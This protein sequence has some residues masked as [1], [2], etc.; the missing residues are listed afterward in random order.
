[1]PDFL[2]KVGSIVLLLGG[3]IFVHE[4]GHFLVAKALGVKVVRFSIG[5][6]ARLFGFRRGETE[7]RISL[8]PLG[9]YVKMAGDDP[10]E[11]LAPE[12]R[13]RGFLE[14]P[15]WK[16]LVIAFAGPA[17]NLIFP[18]II[19]FALMVGQNGEPTAGP[20]VGTVSPGS[21]AA[22]AGLRS[23]DRILSVQAPGQ[24]ATPVRYFN[25]L[26]D[27]VS[28][29]PGEPVTF[30]IEREG[31]TLDPV[32][33]VPATDVESNV[34][35]TTRRGVIGVT[36]FYAP[37]LVAP[38]RPGAA[39]PLEPFD[40]VVSVNGKKIRHL[41]ELEH[42]VRAASCQPVALEVVRE[43]AI[44]LPG[45]TLASFDPARL[46]QVP[47][48]AEGRPTFLPADP[49]LSTFVAA[50][51][52]GSPADKAGLRRGD[53]IAAINGKPVR[54][55]TRDVNALGR[56]F[57]VGKPVALELA[58]GRKTS[59]V[60]ATESYVDDLTK[61][62]AERLLLGFH[63]DRRTLVDPRSLVVA[64]VPLRLGAVEMAE[65]AW[66]ELSRAV[67]YTVLGI[68]RIITGQISFKTVGGPI[69]LFSIASEAAE[70]GWASFLFK[71]AL[72]SVN[73][74]LMN[75]LPIPVLDGGH[76]AQAMV[77]GVTRRPLSLRAREIANIVGIILLF[78]LM[79]FVFKNDIVR[80]MG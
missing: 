37:A 54:S 70:E 38:A 32:T 25:D 20:V 57:Q 41:G 15:P 58:D 33:I 55:F 77:E 18:A 56:E 26:R 62:R 60:P 34:I 76:I 73:L 71:M 78:T 12:D 65:L 50:V 51:V 1:M 79:I 63:P 4:L 72:I 46:D 8:L 29:H 53:A 39:G 6:G 30:R 24:A 16:R 48:C 49:S 14:Q 43:K 10:S 2:L 80:L 28:P 23:G 17:A 69:M 52:P 22:E 59:L 35:E 64:E 9:G 27:L 5:F 36:P 47:T 7:Y 42:A 45:A 75:L 66:R 61:E 44:V 31:A 40:L 13:G 68:Q 67:R 11:E 19:Y 74:G 3:L 21:P